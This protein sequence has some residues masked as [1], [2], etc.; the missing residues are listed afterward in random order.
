MGSPIKQAVIL[1]GGLGTRL[2]PLTYKIPKPMVPVNGKPFLEHLLKYVSSF[3]ITDIV[4]C[5]GYLREHI[6]DHFG[7]GSA[8]GL[9]IQYSIEETPMG[10]GGALKIAEPI[11]ADAFFFMYGDSYMPMNL[12][13]IG[14]AFVGN[15]KP[16]LITVYPNEEKL[17]PNNVRMAS[18]GS[19][20]IYSKD[21][22]TP[23]MNGVE[24]GISVFKKE[25]LDLTDETK[26]SFEK[27]IFSKLINRKELM[28]QF[29][30]TP[31][32]DIGT[33]EGLEKIK[34]IIG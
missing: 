13:G 7:D 9:N 12:E 2:R 11:L 20:E 4:L 28:G 6:I 15:G 27:E 30:N 33:P 22:E 23:D 31:F 5:V 10:T 21:G 14:R 24:A 1:A 34:E 19:I 16:G 17:A 29:V 18:D 32:Y 8:F 25:V 3:G 26:F